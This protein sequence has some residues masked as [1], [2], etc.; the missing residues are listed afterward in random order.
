MLNLALT[1]HPFRAW[2]LGRISN[3]IGDKSTG[4]TLL[5]MEAAGM[6]LS[7]PP[8]G[9]TKPEAHYW[10]GEAAFDLEYARSLDMPV[11]DIKF[12]E[13]ETIEDVFRRLEALCKKHDPKRGVLVVL[14]SVDSITSEGELDTEIDEGSY[15]TEKQ[16]QIG[17]TFRRLTRQIK[18]ANVHLMLI[19]QIRENISRLP[20]APKWRRS[21]GKALDFY[22]THLVWLHERT[23]YKNKKLNLAYGIGVE[24]NVTKNKVARPFRKCEFPILFDYGVD[25]LYSLIDFLSWSKLTSELRIVRKKGG[26]YTWDPVGEDVRL[27]TLIDEID[28]DRDLYLDLIRQAFDAWDWIEEQVSSGRTTKRAML[29]DFTDKDLEPDPEPPKGIDDLDPDEDVPF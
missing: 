27:G 8:P 22:A 4:K 1:G 10:E 7:R 17:Q 29:G 16:R 20:F 2:P 11:D 5:A 15:K 28:G 9:I 23:K 3:V 19:S 13:V 18:A 21:G 12:A 25:D 26:L 6:L 24:A 14:D